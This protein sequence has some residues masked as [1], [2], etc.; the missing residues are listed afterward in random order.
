MQANWLYVGGAVLIFLSVMMLVFA[1]QSMLQYRILP[2]L[3]RDAFF[4]SLWY[5][6]SG[7]GVLWRKTPRIF[8]FCSPSHSSFFPTSNGPLRSKYI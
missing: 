6:V 8:V 7:L 1:A 2:L 3:V 5:T 4:A